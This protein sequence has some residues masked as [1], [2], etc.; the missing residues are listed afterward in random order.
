MNKNYDDSEA[1]VNKIEK[2]CEKKDKLVRKR[3]V[4]TE[5]DE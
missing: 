5:V 2:A 3:T 4:K 1:V